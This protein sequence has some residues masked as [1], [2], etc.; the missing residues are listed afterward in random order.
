MVIDT[1]VHT[2][3]F[4][5]PEKVVDMSEEVVL[6]ALERHNIDLAIVSATAGASFFRVY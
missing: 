3:L 2:G 5:S 1:H 6:E 4:V